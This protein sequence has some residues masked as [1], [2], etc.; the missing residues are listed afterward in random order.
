VQSRRQNSWSVLPQY[1]FEFV[2]ERSRRNSKCAKP[3]HVF[4]GCG[5]KAQIFLPNPNGLKIVCC[6]H[7]GATD[8]LTL[9]RLQD[10]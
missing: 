1:C 9:S 3:G 4:G 5:G 10:D 6:F 7:P 8:D 2:F